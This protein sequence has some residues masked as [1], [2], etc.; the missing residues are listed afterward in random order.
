MVACVF[1]YFGSKS[2]V[3]SINPGWGEKARILL[4]YAYILLWGGMR[5]QLFDINF[6]SVVTSVCVFAHIA[7][8]HFGHQRFDQL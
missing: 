2:L 1:L 4:I 5:C 8:D 6:I 7:D 3:I